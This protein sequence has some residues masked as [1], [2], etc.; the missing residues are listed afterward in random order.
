MRNK[1]TPLFLL[2]TTLISCNQSDELILDNGG[3]QE[4]VALEEKVSSVS[5]ETN[6]NNALPWN[7]L[8]IDSQF[9]FTNPIK[10]ERTTF[11]S[12]PMSMRAYSDSLG[13]EI[14]IYEW[15]LITS[16]MTQDEKQK[17]KL[18]FDD[19][20][21]IYV[22]KYNS[23]LQQIT[24][25]MGAPEQLGDNIK[26]VNMEVYKKWSTESVWK[27]NDRIVELRLLLAPQEIYRIILKNLRLKNKKAE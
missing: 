26:K 12:L 16:D 20:H 11:E 9:V 3:I 27:T 17:L 13:N 19:H 2:L 14:I 23:L 18:S 15:D 8:P 5:L 10:F 22:N 4:A 6:K 24:E 25:E 7:F 21:S 1:L